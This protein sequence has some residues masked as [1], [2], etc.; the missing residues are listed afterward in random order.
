VRTRTIGNSTVGTV[1]VGAIG[2]GEM[3][4][5]LAG[6]LPEK[7]SIRTI[8]RLTEEEVAR[9]K[10]HQITTRRWPPTA[11]RPRWHSL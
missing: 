4:M 5:S 3:P 6:R 1:E 7:Q 8:L 2:L 11:G 10:C 9:L